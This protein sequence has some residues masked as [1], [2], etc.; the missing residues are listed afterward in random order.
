MA[1]SNDQIATGMAVVAGHIR[2]APFDMRARAFLYVPGLYRSLLVLLLFVL[3]IP[4]ANAFSPDVNLRKDFWD[5]D[6]TV[7]SIA[8]TNGKVYLGGAFTYVAPKGSKV[9]S[10]DSLAGFQQ[11]DF[12]KIY[13]AAIYAILQDNNG[14]WFIGGN[15]TSAGGQSVTNLVHIL[16]DNTVDPNFLPNPNGAVHT[17]AQEGSR[18]Y[19]G[20]DFTALAGQS[21]NAIAAWDISSHALLSWSPN[22]NGTVLSLL[23]SGNVV[24]TGGHFTQIGGQL[25]RNI[26]AVDVVSGVAIAW[27]PQADGD[28]LAIGL[29]DQKLYVGGFFNRIGGQLRNG[30]AALDVNSTNALAWNPNPLGGKITTLRA[31]CNSVYVGGYFTNIAGV[32][33][34]RVAALDPETGIASPWNPNLDRFYSGNLPSYVLALEISGDTVY[35]AGQFATIAGQDQHDLAAVDATSGK[36][37]PWSPG[38]DGGVSAVATA[39]R[40]VLGGII[41]ALGGQHR[42]NLAAFDEFSGA[43]LPFGS[44]PAPLDPDAP[45]NA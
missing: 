32:N 38:A 25:R 4:L 42:K 28:V 14:G 43:P 33:R 21:R 18:L 41:T 24:Y 34:I 44:L 29:L 37:I 7:N 16:S 35:I 3:G 5:T 12:P 23:I 2:A 17:L 26:A 11:R 15:F 10:F 27:D 19:I 40:R 8:A 6:G 36:L 45:V 20:G 13:G 30:L 9:I 1:Y 31:A 22:A 39:G